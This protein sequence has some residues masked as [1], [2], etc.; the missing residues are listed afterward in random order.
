MTTCSIFTAEV[1]AILK[2]VQNTSN[3]EEHNF[4]ILTGYLSVLNNLNNRFERF[5]TSK[6]ISNS[7]DNQIENIFIMWTPGHCDTEWNEKSDKS[8]KEIA[9]SSSGK[10]N[11]RL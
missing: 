6:A 5:D 3:L 11:N 8:S 10:I 7:I 9:K 2:A 4:L 1:T